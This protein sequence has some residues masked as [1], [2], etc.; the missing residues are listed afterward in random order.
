MSFINRYSYTIRRSNSDLFYI[1]LNNGLNY[2]YYENSKTLLH[3]INI[4]Q[5]YITDFTY[6][7][8]CI[9]IDDNI[10]GI[11]SYDNLRIIKCEKNEFLFVSDNM[12]EL[13]FQRFGICYPYINKIEDTIHLFYYVYL[14]EENSISYL[15][16]M[17]NQNNIWYQD[18]I[19]CIEHLVLNEYK[20]IFVNNSPIIFYFNMVNNIEELFCSSF[21]NENKKWKNPIQ[22]TNTYKN[23]LYLDVVYK[24]NAFHITFCQKTDNN[25]CIDYLK[26]NYDSINFTNSILINITTPS[27][28]MYPS[29]AIDNDIIYIMWVYFNKIY[30]T[31]SIDNG[32]SW[33][34][35]SCDNSSIN[36]NFLRT[37][38]LSNYNDDKTFSGNNLFVTDDEI[39]FFGF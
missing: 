31:Y 17:Y 37:K 33:S 5:T 3:H 4:L 6:Y 14:R 25:Y 24:N 38:Y 39:K 1:Y 7:D 34:I 2:K 10:Y 11:L 18:K 23:K 27:I 26:L 35:N 30:S 13:D 19:D 12:L 16:H 36:D 8:F 15:Y 32:I 28:Y 20:V 21:D 22:I 9:D 29:F